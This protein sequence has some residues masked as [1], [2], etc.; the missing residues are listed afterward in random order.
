M[1]ACVVCVC[2]CFACI[3]LRACLWS[4]DACMKGGCCVLYGICK[5]LG[6]VDGMVV[7][8][9]TPTAFISTFT[10][11][12]QPQ[13]HFIHRISRSS[14]SS[15]PSPF[16]LHPTFP[17]LPQLTQPRPTTH[18]LHSPLL[19]LSFLFLSFLLS[20]LR[21]PLLPSHPQLSHLE[22]KLLQ[23]LKHLD[24]RWRWLLVRCWCWCLRRWRRLWRR[25]CHFRERKLRVT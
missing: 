4:W 8:P 14:S 20:P 15:F 24:R 11:H 13:P 19:P 18:H 12:S 21:L 3:C 2:V 17:L 23:L 7:D 5:M 6:L 22:L 1:H 10:F 9:T 25:H 16:S